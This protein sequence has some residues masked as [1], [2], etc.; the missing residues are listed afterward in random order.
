MSSPT[1]RTLAQLKATGH[2][3]QVVEQFCQYS[4]QRIDL[5]GF[6]D[7]VA[8]RERLVGLQCTSGSNHSSRVKKIVTECREDALAWINAGGTIEVWSW[9]RYKKAVNRR[10]WRPRI[11]VITAEDFL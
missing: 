11:D 2:R 9:K 8:V 10:F 5:F 1:Q 6:I 3:C 7:I 4:R